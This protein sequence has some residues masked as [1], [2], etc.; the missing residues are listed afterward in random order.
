MR[1]EADISLCGKYTEEE[2]EPGRSSDDIK[3]CVNT[4]SFKD[5]GRER[6]R[7]RKMFN[8]PL[9]PQVPAPRENTENL[10][11]FFHKLDLCYE[12]DNGQHQGLP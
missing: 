8:S 11:F 12:L 7:G 5:F 10:I 9:N 4:L 3:T 1:P 6:E 2:T